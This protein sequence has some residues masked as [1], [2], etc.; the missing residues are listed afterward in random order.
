LFA[1]PANILLS[2]HGRRLAVALAVL[3]S[4]VVASL[5]LWQQL[6][7]HVASQPEYLVATGDLAITPPPVWIHT[8][9]KR[10]AIRDAGLP[11]KL[12]ILDDRLTERISQAFL[13]NP[14]IAR[15]D[16]V[17]TLYPARVQ[18]DLVYRRPAAMVEVF[19]GLLPVDS[20]AVL[21]P[22]EDF[23]PIDAQQYPRI[24]GVKSSP[25][26]PLGTA[27]GDPVVA[28][29][30]KL[31][32]LLHGVWG[33]LQLHHICEHQDHNGGGLRVN[34]AVVTRAGTSII[35]GAAPQDEAADESSAGKKLDRL[36]QW[37]AA[38]SLDSVPIADRDL[39]QMKS[40]ASDSH[41]A[42]QN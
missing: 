22:T 26:G 13:L 37:K 41:A 21:L 34:L 25:L 19:G 20:E 18:V 23:S 30:A 32:D 16:K 27:W 9:L 15:V 8:D 6:R 12:S 36:M 1:A 40:F 39:R 11:A 24:S 2:Q 31:A 14:W 10:A 17:K 38:G 7:T 29:A 3:A 33:D 42:H 5:Q 35:W 28:A 4:I